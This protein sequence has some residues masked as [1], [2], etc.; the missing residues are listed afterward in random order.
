MKADGRSW[1]NVRA[2]LSLLRLD[3]WPFE[4]SR[5]LT[6]ELAWDVAAQ[7]ERYLGLGSLF[8][9][10]VQPRSKVLALSKAYVWPQSQDK[11]MKAQFIKYANAIRKSSG[12]IDERANEVVGFARKLDNV[13]D[14]QPRQRTRPSDSP[15]SRFVSLLGLGASS[16][17]VD[18]LFSKELV[19]TLAEELESAEP[20][21]VMT[22]RAS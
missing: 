21:V 9:I 2:A 6:H 8:S 5:N 1:D 14:H 15:Y 20:H 7:L 4:N 19:T 11:A 18:L 13:R 12:E 17:G 22:I 16:D 3:G 10:S